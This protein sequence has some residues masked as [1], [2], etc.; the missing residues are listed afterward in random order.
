MMGTIEAEALGKVRL[1]IKYDEVRQRCENAPREVDISAVS[2]AFAAWDDDH[3][4]RVT[5]EDI[6]RFAKK[7][8]M[9]APMIGWDR[10]VMMMVAEAAGR[11]GFAAPSGVLSSD[12]YNPSVLL[13]VQ[14]SSPRPLS[15]PHQSLI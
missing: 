1:P 3:D 4:G 9:Q 5:A 13:V 11:T 2:H 10:Q 12:P 15:R 7:Q 14:V 8:T 6:V